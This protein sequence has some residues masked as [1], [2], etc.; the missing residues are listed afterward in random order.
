MVY[1]NDWVRQLSLFLMTI[2]KS[3]DMDTDHGYMSSTSVI[4]MVATYF[5][6][7]EICPNY[8]RPVRGSG[9]EGKKMRVQR[10]VKESDNIE[11]RGRSYL[12]E[13]NLAIFNEQAQPEPDFQK[14]DLRRLYR[15]TKNP[16]WQNVT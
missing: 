2:F 5:M 14:P 9:E 6:S 16:E 7:R 15:K 3:R 12:N 11:K 8:L 1:K 10:K 13:Q 4:L